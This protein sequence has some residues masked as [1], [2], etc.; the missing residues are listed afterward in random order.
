VHGQTLLWLDA[1]GL[2][3]YACVG[4][5]KAMS[6]GVSPVVCVVMGAL[7]ATF[8]GIIRDVLAG[9]P[10]ILLSRELYITPAIVSSAVFVSLR[11]LGFD[12]ALAS[13]IAVAFGFAVR[14]GAIIWKWSLPEF[15][16]PE[17][18]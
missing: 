17:G 1:V 2:C 3:V 12:W 13:A 9:V 14:G 4:A 16:P 15:K 11:T 6:L 8:G 5:A 18:R 10:S 7:T